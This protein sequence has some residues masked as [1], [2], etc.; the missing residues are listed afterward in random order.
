MADKK[1]KEKEK[2]K[3]DEGM[4]ARGLKGRKA[5][6]EELMKDDRKKTPAPEKK[7][8]ST[9]SKKILKGMGYNV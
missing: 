7:G 6:M 9:Q 2:E 8:G 4:A 5:A 3:E 1:K